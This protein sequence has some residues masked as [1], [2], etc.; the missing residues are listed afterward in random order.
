MTK[1]IICKNVEKKYGF[2][3]SEVLAL[4]GVSVEVNTGELLMLVGPSGCGKTTL[5]SIMSGV[6]TQDAGTCEVLGEEINSMENDKKTFFRGKNI[7]FVFQAFNLIP[8]L[9][10]KEN[11]SIPLIINGMERIKA[12]QIAEEYLGKVGLGSRVDAYPWELSGGE[13]QRVAIVRSC[14][15]NPKIIVSDEP[16]SN[17]DHEA[18]ENVLELLKEIALRKDSAV[19]IVT[20]DN[21][22]LHFASRI[23][24]MEDG[25]ILEEVKAN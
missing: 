20:H 2:K 25:K 15:H 14:I 19:I 21:R 5:L 12:L 23:L 11:A 8:M 10:A 18:G 6:L 22:I 16:T 24:K 13:K 17:L 1:A 3:K 9:T 4:R 7:G